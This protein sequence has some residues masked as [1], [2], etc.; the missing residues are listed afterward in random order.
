MDSLEAGSLIC[1]EE[2]LYERLQQTFAISEMTYQS[3]FSV[4]LNRGVVGQ[5]AVVLVPAEQSQSPSTLD[6]IDDNTSVFVLYGCTAGW[7]SSFWHRES[8][9]GSHWLWPVSSLAP[10]MWRSTIQVVA[11]VKP[12]VMIETALMRVKAILNDS[13][14]DIC[15]L[16]EEIQVLNE[17]ARRRREP[18]NAKSISVEVPWR[19]RLSDLENQVE[20]C[21]RT[22]ALLQTSL[23]FAH[24]ELSKL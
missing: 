5:R 13:D 11:G 8:R 7:S 20:E 16:L 2:D 10:A 3:K 14:L 24:L 23:A 1:S 19:T 22:I 18:L 4:S 12:D 17:E 15:G 6:L 21:Q 9:L